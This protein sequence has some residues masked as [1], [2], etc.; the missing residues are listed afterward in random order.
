[1]HINTIIYW[2]CSND[3]VWQV[4]FKVI[5]FSALS[6]FCPGSFRLIKSI[7]AEPGSDW[8]HSL[9]N[10]WNPSNRWVSTRQAY[11][12]WIR[13]LEFFYHSVFYVSFQIWSEIVYLQNIVLTVSQRKKDGNGKL[14]NILSWYNINTTYRTKTMDLSHFVRTGGHS[15]HNF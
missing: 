10:D 4:E 14:H 6:P 12:V 1:M 11:L 5:A 8:L 15:I 9:R 13:E 7:T 3:L 2:H